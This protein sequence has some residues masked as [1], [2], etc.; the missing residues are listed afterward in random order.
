MICEEQTKAQ[1]YKDGSH[2]NACS[3]EGI[4][5]HIKVGVVNLTGEPMHYNHDYQ[6]DQNYC[7]K[8]FYF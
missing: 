7:P 8:D 5:S 2:Q 1:Y 6:T 3:N 4:V